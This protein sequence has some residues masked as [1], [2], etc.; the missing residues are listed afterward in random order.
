MYILLATWIASITKVTDKHY[1][2]N[3][4]IYFKFLS[5]YKRCFRKTNVCVGLVRVRTM[6]PVWQ[7]GGVPTPN[8]NVLRTVIFKRPCCYNSLTSLRNPLNTLQIF[9]YFNMKNKGLV[10]RRAGVLCFEFIISYARRPVDPCRPLGRSHDFQLCLSLL[11]GYRE[12][13]E[14][15]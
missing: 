11:F 1:R 10:A 12:I 9:S 3:L 6:R 13:T 2:A 8:G 4:W 5:E 14:R 15:V 7:R